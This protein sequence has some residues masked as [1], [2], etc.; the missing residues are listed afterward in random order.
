MA[1]T[2]PVSGEASGWVA[3]D[4]DEHPTGAELI[5]RYL[6]PLGQLPEI[7][8][9]LRT[10]RLVVG[11]ARAGVDKVRTP[12][13][14]DRPFVVLTESPHGPERTLVRAVIDASGTWLSPNPLGAGGLIARGEGI[15]ADRIVHGIP[16]V[17]GRARRYYTGRRVAVV[18]SGHSAQNVVRDLAQL[19]ERSPGT[20]ITWVIRRADAGQMFGGKTDDRL[21]ERGRLGADAEHLVDT[22][23]VA[24]VPGFRVAAVE[25]VPDGGVMLVAED[26]VR[27]GPFDEIVAAT[28]FRPDL[29]FLRELRIDVD[30]TL[31]SARALA[32]LIDPNVHS[33]GSVPPH[34]AAELTHPEAGLYLVGAKSYGRAPTFLLATGYEQVRSVVAEIAGDHTAAADTR[35]ELPATG[36][37]SL[38]NRPV[39]AVPADGDAVSVIEPVDAVEAVDAIPA[40]AGCC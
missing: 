28:G 6:T 15:A 1:D 36:V 25:A 19:A 9:H 10:N 8:A 27:V 3:P 17:L 23:Q 35:L 38:D 39:A 20:E 7:A 31:E 34:G 5:D 37:C 18:G 21:P 24:L 13:R 11:I 26:G 29:S 33:C 22:G 12:G 32:A 40:A 14:D 2:Q 4:P 30:P 16:D